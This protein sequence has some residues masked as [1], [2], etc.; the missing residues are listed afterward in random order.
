MTLYFHRTPHHRRHHQLKHIAKLGNCFGEARLIYCHKWIFMQIG[1]RSLLNSSFNGVLHIARHCIDW[2]SD[3]LHNMFYYPT[4][5]AWTRLISGFAINLIQGSQLATVL[6]FT[7]ST[8]WFMLTLSMKRINRTT[9]TNSI[10]L[11]FSLHNEPLQLQT[12]MSHFKRDFNLLALVLCC[13]FGPP[14]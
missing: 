11:S 4:R 1:N 5:T 7:Y 2:M 9:R 14:Q 10:S 8:L 12:N 6:V 13:S 3:W